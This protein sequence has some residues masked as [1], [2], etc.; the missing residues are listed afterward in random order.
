MHMYVSV[1]ASAS[2]NASA[3]EQLHMWSCNVIGFA[4]SDIWFDFHCI[5]KRFATYYDYELIQNAMWYIVAR[6][7]CVQVSVQVLFAG[8]VVFFLLF[9]YFINESSKFNKKQKCLLQIRANITRT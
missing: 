1:S 4:C 2:A 8:I 9:T 7:Q 3:N 5:S 6:V